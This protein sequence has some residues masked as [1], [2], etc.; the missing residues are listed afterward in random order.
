[1]RPADSAIAIFRVSARLANADEG[2][3][4]RGLGPCCAI[5]KFAPAISKETT[6]ILRS[7][8][9]MTTPCLR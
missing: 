8:L 4:D 1:M 5:A 9:F 2:A 6:A 3:A 7:T